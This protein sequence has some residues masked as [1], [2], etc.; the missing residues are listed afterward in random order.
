MILR[1]PG[2]D[3]KSPRRPLLMG[4]V[5]INDDSFSGDGTLDIEEALQMAR[6]H[7]AEGA[8]IIDIGAESA[9]TNREAISV[10]EE[11]RRLRAFLEKW[12]ALRDEAKGADLEQHHFD[13]DQLDRAVTSGE[14]EGFIDLFTEKGK[15]VGATVVGPS[16]GETINELTARVNDGAKL[17]TVASMIRPYPTYGEAIAKAANVT[18]SEEFF[19]DRNKLVAGKVLAFL[20]KFDS[21]GD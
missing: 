1:L 19:N 15:I 6:S 9:R 8:D 14:P 17:R 3:L 12:P 5:N 20:G 10:E 11:V 13:Y 2:R 7:I 21:A 16:A 4:I 18:L